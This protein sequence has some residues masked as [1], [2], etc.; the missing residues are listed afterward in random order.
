[1][2]GAGCRFIEPQWLTGTIS[3]HNKRKPYP[4]Q[5]ACDFWQS[6]VKIRVEE[7]EEDGEIELYTYKGYVIPNM[8]TVTDFT[9]QPI[10][11]AELRR[12]DKIR[13]EYQTKIGTPLRGRLLRVEILFR[14]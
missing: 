13:F 9:G 7:Q 8:T 1:M 12:G 2:P 11:P 3:A 4:F 10:D 14:T 5:S 6:K